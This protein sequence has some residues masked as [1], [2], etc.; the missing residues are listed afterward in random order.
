MWKRYAASAGALLLCVLILLLSILLF[1]YD[2][3]SYGF[4]EPQTY[5]VAA[6]NPG[7]LLAQSNADRLRNGLSLLAENPLLT[8]AA[9]AKADDMLRRGY[10]AHIT[11]EGNTPLYFADQVGYKYLNFGENLDLTYIS[12]EED[13]ETAWMNSPT[14]RQN[15]LTPQFTEVGVGVASG[16]YQGNQVTFAVELYATPLPTAAPKPKIPAPSVTPAISILFKPAAKENT[17]AP[18]SE[19]ALSVFIKSSAAA[20]SSS[21]LSDK[22]PGALLRS[23]S[24]ASFGI[25]P[26]LP[27]VATSSPSTAASSTVNATTSPDTRA[28]GDI[29]TPVRQTFILH[30]SSSSPLQ[31]FFG[32]GLRALFTQLLISFIK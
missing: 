30:P 17:L 14:H 10:Y 19:T 24:R 31:A 1:R 29:S 16:E 18:K 7:I 32:A 5:L 21:S 12:T 8:R 25:L 4:I 28:S 20:V 13:V 3:R 11:P 2:L 22:S 26:G 15:L 27:T 9:Q 23:K 6:V